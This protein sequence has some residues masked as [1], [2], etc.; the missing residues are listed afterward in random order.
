VGAGKTGISCFAENIRNLSR[1]SLLANP[2]LGKTGIT[3]RSLLTGSG[4]A[5]LE[6]VDKSASTAVVPIRY[7]S[8]I[9]MITREPNDG[10]LF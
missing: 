5:C 9:Q 6:I 4:L 2:F 8:V 7:R 3:R 1:G 10:P